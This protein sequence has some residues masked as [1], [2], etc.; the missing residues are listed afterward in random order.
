V[1]DTFDATTFS[2]DAIGWIDFETRSDTDIKAGTYRYA[3]EADAIVLAYAIGDGPVRTVSVSAFPGN[4][5]WVDMPR[6][7]QSFHARVTRGE[8]IWA[9]WNAGFD[10]AIW[11][12]AAIGCPEMLPH[13]IIDVMAQATAS[14]LPPDLSKAARSSQ[15]KEKLAT[16][17]QLIGLFCS[18]KGYKGTRGTPQSHPAEWQAFLAYAGGDVEAMRSV[19]HGTRQ[20]PLREWQ[21]YWAMEAIN[22]RGVGIDLDMVGH[23]ARLAAEDKVRSKAA[24]AK[25]TAGYVHSVDQ[26]ARISEWLR[27]QLPPEGIAI[28][29]AREEEVDEE[30]G[31]VMRPAKYALTRK[32]V[33]R[34]IAYCSDRAA[35]ASLLTSIAPR[36]LLQVL[37]I[38][39]YGGSKTPAKF[40]RMLT[41]HV[42]G[43]LFGQYVFNGASQTGRASSKGVQIHNLAR[44]P[45]DYE[46]DAVDALLTG[47]NYDELAAL[48]DASPVARKLSLLIRPAFV[49]RETNVFV[50]SD[51]SQIE[52]RV[53]PWL[54]DHYRGARQRL[55]I[56][57]DVDADPDLPDLYTRTAA[58][59]SH[60]PVAQVTKAMRQRGKVAELALGFCGGVNALQAMAAAYG[61][62]LDDIEA[63]VIVE[64]WRAANPWAIDY[65]R[66]IWE[67]MR[68]AMDAPGKAFQAGRIWLRFYPGYLGGT[69]QC[70]LPSGRRLTY[71]AMRWENIDVLDADD[72]PTGEKKLELTFAR[73][74]GRIKIWPGLF[75]ENFTQA[76]AADFLRGTLERLQNVVVFPN[77]RAPALS[78]DV[79]LHT[80]DEVL[81]ECEKARAEEAA[82]AL[83]QIMR[84][85]FDWSEGLPLMSEETIAYAYSKH[86]G[87]HGL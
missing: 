55:Q 46:P 3:T 86:E 79:R 66:E 85:G 1:T 27:H 2:S 67:A 49:P 19:F 33:E 81:V 74:Y 83:R 71:R 23:A 73:G 87:S 26:V 82:G 75:V 76:C 58:D 56:F 54:C 13:H 45:L 41:Q 62:H 11:N 39:L 38:R 34:L 40:G 4:I 51:W 37:Q 61:M 59:L 24:L 21:E 17:R 30:T 7:L 80:H 53:L 52:A 10:R 36:T 35:E 78:L 68:H 50:W 65:S 60:V 20:L 63:K 29:T 70:R 5:N 72:K 8:A 9:A 31:L 64:R 84:Q 43:V 15:S 32:R 42:D 28:L 12:Y 44:D 6:E 48:G 16:G 22:G 18:P 14:G 77:G 57:R 69:L 25:L 47:A